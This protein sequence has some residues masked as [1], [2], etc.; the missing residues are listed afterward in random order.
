MNRFGCAHKR[1]CST[2][3]SPSF[4][5]SAATPFTPL[6]AARTSG[7]TTRQNQTEPD[8]FKTFQNHNS[9]DLAHL[10]AEGHCSQSMKLSWKFINVTATKKKQQLWP[11]D[12]VA[13]LFWG[14]LDLN[15]FEVLGWQVWSNKEN[16]VLNMIRADKPL[17][18]DSK[19]KSAAHSRGQAKSHLQGTWWVL[20]FTW[21]SHMCFFAWEAQAFTHRG[22]AS[23]T[24]L[25]PQVVSQKWCGQVSNLIRWPPHGQL[26]CHNWALAQPSVTFFLRTT[27]VLWQAATWLAVGDLL[28][29]WLCRWHNLPKKGLCKK[30]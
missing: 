6:S 2:V 27:S 7:L 21:Y 28:W 30:M 29:Y 1:L 19:I 11:Y 17:N 16:C 25:W 13:G 22:V 20:S 14:I 12:Q 23:S 15:A 8:L 24:S 5:V 18:A 3:S 10:G 9:K 4:S 26:R